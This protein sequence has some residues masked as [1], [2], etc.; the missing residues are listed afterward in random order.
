[1]YHKLMLR[2][3]RKFSTSGAYAWIVVLLLTLVW[4]LNYLD[5]QVLFSVFPLLEKELHI[6][7]FQLGL[8]GTSFLWVYAFSS[9]IAGYL[10]D[11]IGSKRMICASLLVWSA[12]T[13]ATGHARSFER[14]LWLRSL[15]G[16]SEACY[17]PA[18]LALIA[19]F[20]SQRTRAKAI[21]LHYSG[22]YIGTVLGGTLGGLLAACYGWRSVFG[23][24]GAI[25]CAYAVVLLFTLRDKAP[26]EERPAMARRP[27]RESVVEIL[28]T[29]GYR[30]LLIVFAIASVCDWAIYTWMPFYL[31]ES[32]HFSLA[33]AGF[34]ATFY[35]KAGGFAG[36]LVGGFLGDAWFRRSG[37]GYVFTQTAGLL[38]AAPFLALSGITRAPAILY[39]G[40]VL[41]GLGKGMYDGNT[42]PV[43]CEGV[44]PDRRAT[45]FGILNF[46][47]TF[48]GGI[49]AAGAGALKSY[50]GLG[51]IFG[52]CGGLLL[53]GSLITFQIRMERR[54]VNGMTV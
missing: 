51:P 50:I 25:G 48:C 28:T 4:M 35:I 32:F 12:V 34:A 39:V 40:M 16:I 20:H 9:P 31:F 11:R 43:L 52:I 19:A 22:T 44:D 7:A 33:K 29:P 2:S 5:R 38:L 54:P 23:I 13:V 45:A 8:L 1:M 24:F 17:L 36:L 37:S 30:K 21:S 53:V 47:G 10:A 18:G 15:M 46:A 26:V 3:S 27:V 6:S 42:M 41:F 14:L 49:V